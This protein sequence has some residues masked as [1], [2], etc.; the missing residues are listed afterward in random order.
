MKTTVS[1]IKMVANMVAITI[2]SLCLFEA[3]AP[4]EETQVPDSYTAEV[5]PAKPT[6]VE[7]LI[8]KHDCW[9]GEAPKDMTG[10]MPGGVVVSAPNAGPIYDRN[11]HM[12]GY[13]LDQIFNVQDHNLTVHAFCR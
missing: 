1:I 7:R 3:L 2:A 12:V 8:E 11:Q 5:L 6:K 4:V 10:K 13:A 9:T